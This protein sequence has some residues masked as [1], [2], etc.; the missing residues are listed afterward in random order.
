MPNCTR[1]S[2]GS[3]GLPL[4]NNIYLDSAQEIQPEFQDYLVQSGRNKQFQEVGGT[5]RASLFNCPIN[6][7]L[8]TNFRS[9]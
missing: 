4:N 8:M 9:L 6:L 5:W 2:T 3:T 1:R 7:R